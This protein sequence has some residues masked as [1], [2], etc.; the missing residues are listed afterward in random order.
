MFSVTFKAPSN[1]WWTAKSATKVTESMH[2]VPQSKPKLNQEEKG[3]HDVIWQGMNCQET[4]SK[5]GCKY[6]T[7]VLSRR[8]TLHCLLQW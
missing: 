6:R 1:T 5:Q 7:F 8:L 3:S 2:F 4:E